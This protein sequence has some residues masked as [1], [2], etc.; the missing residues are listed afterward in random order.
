MRKCIETLILKL[1]NETAESNRNRMP[2]HSKTSQKSMEKN[3]QI[4]EQFV[5]S[6]MYAT[7]VEELLRQEEIY[8][9]AHTRQIVSNLEQVGAFFSKFK[10]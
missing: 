6:E 5:K 8:V 10:N 2:T 1:Y 9:A 3:N 7:Q 4:C